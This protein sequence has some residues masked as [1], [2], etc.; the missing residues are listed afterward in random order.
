VRGKYSVDVDG[1][2]YMGLS[3]SEA[4]KW[5]DL[6]QH[7]NNPFPRAKTMTL[8][9]WHD[10]PPCSDTE[11]LDLHLRSVGKRIFETG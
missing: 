4:L 1:E 8:R 5:L 10:V 2:R 3:T 11:C 7:G 6:F 9:R